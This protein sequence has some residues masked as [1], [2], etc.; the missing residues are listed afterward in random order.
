MRSRVE[1]RAA[2]DLSRVGAGALAVRSPSAIGDRRSPVESTF[3][4]EMFDQLSQL[5]AKADLLG[6]SE[7]NTSQESQSKELGSTD[8]FST[9]VE[10]TLVDK[11][12]FRLVKSRKNCLAVFLE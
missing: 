1:D 11:M 3:W 5:G 6:W 8:D 4:R 10:S 12:L 7:L 2:T 9:S